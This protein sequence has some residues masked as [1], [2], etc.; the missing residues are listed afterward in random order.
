M[1]YLRLASL[2]LS[3]DAFLEPIRNKL[4]KKYGR[5]LADLMFVNCDDALTFKEYILSEDDLK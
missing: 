2:G 1:S 4:L 3:F 5:N